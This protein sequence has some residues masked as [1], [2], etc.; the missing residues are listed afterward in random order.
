MNAV[1]LLAA[2]TRTSVGA[3]G[4]RSIVFST[5]SVLVIATRCGLANF[6]GNDSDEPEASDPPGRAG[7]T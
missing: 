6:R 2:T 1:E 4:G 3:S 7:L 5:C